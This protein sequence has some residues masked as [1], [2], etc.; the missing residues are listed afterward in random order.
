MMKYYKT[1]RNTLKFR[2]QINCCSFGTK[3]PNEQQWKQIDKVDC[4]T[5]PASIAV[6]NLAIFPAHTAHRQLTIPYSQDFWERPSFMALI[7]H[8]HMGIFFLL[9]GIMSVPRWKWLVKAKTVS[10]QFF[11]VCIF[12]QNRGGY[13]SSHKIY[14]ESA[15][16]NHVNSFFSSLFVKLSKR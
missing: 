3:H 1:W 13:E 7:L 5:A 16:K 6:K 14:R 12:E 4:R 11:T 10:Q 15:K 2:T 9:S 8:W